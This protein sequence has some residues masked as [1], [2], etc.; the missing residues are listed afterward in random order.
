MSRFIKFVV[1]VVFLAA[2]ALWFFPSD[3]KPR[4]QRTSSNTG[5][6]A[7]TNSAATEAGKPVDLSPAAMINRIFDQL[8]GG[9]FTAEDLAAFRRNLLATDPATAI[10][11]ITTF[12]ATGQDAN[13]GERFQVGE[14]GELSGAPTLRVLLLDLLGRIC[15]KSGGSEAAVLARDLMERKTS[16]DEWAIALRNVGWT[17]PDERTY[18]AGKMREMLRYEAWKRQPSGGYIESFDIIVFTRDVSFT[19]E[20][21]E[22]VKGED[23][24]LQ[25]AAAVAMDRLSEMNPLD[26]MNWLNA[27]PDEF[28][29]KPMLRADYFSKADFSQPAQRQAVETYLGRI[30]VEQ[31][32]KIKLLNAIAAP[33]TFAAEGLLTPPPPEN[34]APEK[35]AALQS[36][37]GNWV[38]NNRF[39]TL[40]PSLLQLQA[41][42]TE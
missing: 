38:K 42:I 24:A 11:A 28:S 37:V 35:F 17:T 29:A 9:S 30:D 23:K 13:T 22:L 26:V 20:L 25:R 40:L 8:R 3:E 19:P 1:L 12:L 2:V 10:A 41:R 16:A 4:P 6:N 15:R 31:K 39:P 5:E 34:D 36:T 33:G 7:A 21:G 18:L 27:N 32:E 14:R